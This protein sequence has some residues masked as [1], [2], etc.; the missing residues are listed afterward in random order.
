MST[1]QFVYKD[2]TGVVVTNTFSF[3]DDEE[4]LEVASL[5]FERFGVEVIHYGRT[6]G[7]YP[8]CRTIGVS[9][10]DDIVMT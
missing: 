7:R 3:A 1:Y 2:G 4:A 8:P 10:R 9:P 5:T 6:V